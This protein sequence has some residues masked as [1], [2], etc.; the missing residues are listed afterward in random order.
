MTSAVGIAAYFLNALAPLVEALEPAQ[1]LSAFYYYIG[2]DPLV[3]GLNLAHAA[4]LVGLIVA[5]LAVALVTFE[6]R[7]LRV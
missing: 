5:A 1:K 3:N 4:V 2:A 6:R 7:D